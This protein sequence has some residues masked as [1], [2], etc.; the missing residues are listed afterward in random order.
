MNEIFYQL[1]HMTMKKEMIAFL[2]YNTTTI[3]FYGKE[4]E[5][6]V[7]PLDKQKHLRD[8]FSFLLAT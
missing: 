2:V 4:E 8:S 7:N 6:G 3:R 1:G 5:N